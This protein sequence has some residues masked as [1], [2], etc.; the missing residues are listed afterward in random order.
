[1][2]KQEQKLQDALQQLDKILQE[3]GQKDVEIGV[4][5]E[6][7]REGMRLLKVCKEQLQEAENEF[8]K[9]KTELE[10]PAESG[11]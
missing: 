3:L 10:E 8:R 11:E 6:K 1:M 4:G 2:A 9:L 7:Y 5:M